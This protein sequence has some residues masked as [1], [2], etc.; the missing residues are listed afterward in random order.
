MI[1]IAKHKWRFVGT[2]K[3]L[4]AVTKHI[5]SCTT[6]HYATTPPSDSREI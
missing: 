2:I 3:S 6:F 4:V 1:S 5:K